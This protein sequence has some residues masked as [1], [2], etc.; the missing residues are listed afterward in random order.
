MARKGGVYGPEG[1]GVSHASTMEYKH[2]YSVVEMKTK[3]RGWWRARIG[4]LALYSRRLPRGSSR[5][6]T[7]GLRSE[8]RSGGD[9]GRRCWSVVDTLMHS[10]STLRLLLWAS[11]RT[12]MLTL[13]DRQV[14]S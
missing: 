1:T 4:R 10:H 2:S 13:L 9:S 3:S 12:M 14:H 8:G 6:S 11:L 7:P 5:S